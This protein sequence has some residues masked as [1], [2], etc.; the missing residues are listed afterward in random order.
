MTQPL[1]SSV[2]ISR[3]N[4]AAPFRR[5]KTPENER[6]CSSLNLH[7][8]QPSL[9]WHAEG[10]VCSHL[11]LLGCG[12]F[13]SR[14]GKVFG[15]QG[16]QITLVTIFRTS[17]IL[18]KEFSVVPKGD[19]R[20]LSIPRTVYPPLLIRSSHSFREQLWIHFLFRLLSP[21]PILQQS[22]RCFQTD[23]ICLLGVIHIVVVS[24]KKHRYFDS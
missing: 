17:Q 21:V 12:N 11:S 3:Y 1:L 20:W 22:S 19:G 4:T 18:Q 7:S 8:P 6:A 9:S 5:D 15:N 23:L 2:A 14:T 24:Q 10:A 13:R 16:L